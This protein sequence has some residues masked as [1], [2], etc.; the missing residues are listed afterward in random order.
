MKSAIITGASRGIGFETALAFARA[1]YNVFATVRN[2]DGVAELKETAA[3]E[4]LPIKVLKMDVNSDESVNDC[5]HAIYEETDTIDVLVNN[6]G[7]ERHG[8]IE[9]MT[10]TDFRDVMETNYF[11]VLRCT[12]AVIPQMRASRDGCIINISS[13]AGKIANTPLGAYAPTKHAL[14]AVSEALAQELKQHHIRVVI[15]QPGI[16]D[17]DM[18]QALKPGVSSIYPQVN[19]FGGLFQAS[20]KSP[21]PS[22]MVADKILEIADSSSWQ[23]RHPVGPDAAPFLG[24]RGTMTDEQWVDWNAA[25]DE[26]WFD[27]VQNTF[28]MDVR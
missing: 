19:R 16:I 1:G 2:P 17:T 11:G 22:S 24:W 10:L 6:A 4:S 8:S 5:I 3:R 18:A 14:E 25:E 15:V 21:R 20:L 12:K 13:V 28:G 9:E 26:V 7:I 27:A 23:L